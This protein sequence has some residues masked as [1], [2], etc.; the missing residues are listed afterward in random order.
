MRLEDHLRI[1]SNHFA[2]VLGGC[3]PAARGPLP[4]RFPV[5]APR[6]P[7]GRG[8]GCI[9]GGPPAPV[10]IGPVGLTFPWGGGPFIG[11]YI[12]VLDLFW[13]YCCCWPPPELELKDWFGP[14]P[15]AFL[16][17]IFFYSSSFLLCMASYRSSDSS[18]SSPKAVL[19]ISGSLWRTLMAF[20]KTSRVEL[21]DFLSSAT[22]SGSPSDFEKD[23]FLLI[24]EY[25]SNWS[26]SWEDFTRK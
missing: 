8:Y 15:P 3:P 18:S 12:M 5:G 16:S 9:P 19:V 11:F 21:R 6:G 22:R 13:G 26:L 1:N 24:C 23:S 14:L 10:P 4:N 7:V 2:P 20:F 25:N 17:P